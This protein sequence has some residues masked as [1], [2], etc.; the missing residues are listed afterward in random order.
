MEPN[1]RDKNAAANEARCIISNYFTFCLN[2]KRQYRLIPAH[3]KETVVVL[4]NTAE[5]H[6]AHAA[7]RT[8]SPG[9]AIGAKRCTAHFYVH[10]K[11]IAEQLLRKLQKQ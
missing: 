11:F 8:R 4:G 7:E 6:N 10:V 9:Q 2:Q 3:S 1:G 5:Q